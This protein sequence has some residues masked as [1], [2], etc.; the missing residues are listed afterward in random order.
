MT[1]KIVC[2]VFFCN[3]QASIENYDLIADSSV[4]GMEGCAE[5]IIRAAELKK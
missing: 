3:S 4:F 1:G 5:L 2:Q